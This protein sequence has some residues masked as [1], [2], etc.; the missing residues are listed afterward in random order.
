MIFSDDAINDL[1]DSNPRPTSDAL[2]EGLKALIESAHSH[3][4]KF[5]CS[6]LTPYQ[7]AGYWS[8]QGEFARADI[9]KFILGPDNKCDGIVD[10]DSATHDPSNPTRFLPA[11]DSG[12]HLHP[13]DAGMQ[14]IANA[15][16][17]SLFS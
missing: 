11:Y 9:N 5:I 14:A 4:I 6:T 13:N 12:D 10:Q 3:G 1:G 17:L 16:K 7:G 15:V 2:I 8:T